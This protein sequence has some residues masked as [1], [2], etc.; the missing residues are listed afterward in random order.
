MKEA[1]ISFVKSLVLGYLDV[2][3]NFILDSDSC[4]TTI[5]GVLAQEN[6]YGL[7][8]VTWIQHEFHNHEKGYYIIR[9]QL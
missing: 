4:F 1:L 6:D 2:N 5:G 8:R 3:E 9:K 7:E